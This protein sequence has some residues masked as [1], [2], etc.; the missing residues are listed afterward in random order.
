MEGLHWKKKAEALFFVEK[1]GVVEIS[2]IMGISRK[3]ISVHLKTVDG[4]L[5]EKET[6]KKENA[7]KRK[8]SKR[9]W[10]RTNRPNRYSGVNGDTLRR[11]HDTAALI[12]S[13]EKYY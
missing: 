5:K 8:E 9:N 13:R 10:D 1:R 7:K 11:E 6:R 12:L 4:F 3:S 2:K